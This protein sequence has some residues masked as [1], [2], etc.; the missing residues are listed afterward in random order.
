MDLSEKSTDRRICVPL[1]SPLHKFNIYL[2]KDLKRNNTSGNIKSVILIGKFTC[3]K[4][5]LCQK[6]NP[7]IYHAAVTF[8]NSL[9]INEV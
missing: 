7:R 6:C 8:S 4:S 9:I 1:F 5:S 2:L 3:Q